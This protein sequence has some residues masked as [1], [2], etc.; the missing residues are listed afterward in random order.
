MTSA[1]STELQR[2]L[3]T[4]FDAQGW[5]YDLAIG[6]KIVEAVRKRGTADPEHLGSSRKRSKMRS[7]DGA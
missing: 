4:A 2:L 1:T 7:A 3:A 5:E 6:P